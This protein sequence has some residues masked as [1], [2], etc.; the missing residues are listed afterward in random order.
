MKDLLLSK[1]WIRTNGCN[2]GGVK[3]EEFQHSSFPGMIVKTYPTKQ[4]YRASKG[5]RKLSEGPAGEL[6]N[7]L[8][9]ILA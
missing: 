6:E 2:C 7:Y 1:G 4:K 9:G 8:N 3:R 5:G